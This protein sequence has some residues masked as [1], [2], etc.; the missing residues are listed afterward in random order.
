M[1]KHRK[2]SYPSN[3]CLYLQISTNLAK[4]SCTKSKANLYLNDNKNLLC[5]CFSF[6]HIYVQPYMDIN[7][8]TIQRG[9][10]C[11]LFK[12]T[13]GRMWSGQQYKIMVLAAVLLSVVHPHPIW[14]CGHTHTPSGSFATDRTGL[15]AIFLLRPLTGDILP[16]NIFKTAVKRE[17]MQCEL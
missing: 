17:Q 7:L 4:T 5:A 8:Y 10:H 9:M 14:F 3:I 15:T 12:H 6:P 11:S 16:S 1:F 2:I 13:Q